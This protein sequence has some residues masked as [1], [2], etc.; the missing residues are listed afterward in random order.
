MDEHK[1]AVEN[2]LKA[3]RLAAKATR[4]HLREIALLLAH[5]HLS[6]PSPET[7]VCIHRWVGLP[8]DDHVIWLT[9]HVTRCDPYIV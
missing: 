3:N 2:L 9:S 8:C 4:S 7:F 1:D 5:N 6:S